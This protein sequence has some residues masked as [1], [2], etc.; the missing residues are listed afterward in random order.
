MKI[1]I[2][3]DKNDIK[4]RDKA[5]NIEYISKFDTCHYASLLRYGVKGLYKT[6]KHVNA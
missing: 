3:Y 5:V 6:N 2:K 1:P 4:N